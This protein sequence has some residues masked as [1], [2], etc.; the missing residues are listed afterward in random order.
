MTAMV[1]VVT[2]MIIDGDGCAIDGDCSGDSRDNDVSDDGGDEDD[3]REDHLFDMRNVDM[4]MMT[5]L[6]DNYYCSD[7]DDNDNVDDGDNDYNIM[8][9]LFFLSA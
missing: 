2:A 1:V 3:D 9:T 7:Y 8:I 5:I 6:G 4:T